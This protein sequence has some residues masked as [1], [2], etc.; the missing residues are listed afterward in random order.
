[1]PYYLVLDIEF[2][3][4]LLFSS[5]VGTYPALLSCPL[6]QSVTHIAMIRGIIDT[7]GT[8]MDLQVTQQTVDECSREMW[9]WLGPQ[10]ACSSGPGTSAWY[11][12]SGG[13]VFQDSNRLVGVISSGHPHYPVLAFIQVGF[14][15]N[16]I[17]EV[18]LQEQVGLGSR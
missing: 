4:D 17:E 9:E 3:V 8:T 6:L 5:L 10:H 15:M 18:S 12:D 14:L 7:T 11:G 2:V 13:P 1:M 16:W